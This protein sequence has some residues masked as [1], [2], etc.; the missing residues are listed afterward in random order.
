MKFKS[1]TNRF[2]ENSNLY[3]LHFAQNFLIKEQGSM[4]KISIHQKVYYKDYLTII[5]LNKGLVERL[6][7]YMGV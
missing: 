7:D 1:S 2:N 4:Y 5:G 6:N 3:I